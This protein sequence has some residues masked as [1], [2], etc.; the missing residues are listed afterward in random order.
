M[1]AVQEY[2]CE[3]VVIDTVSRSIE[4]EENSNDT[5]LNFYK[6]TGLRLKQAGVALIRLDHSGKD[7]MRGQRGASAKSG[8]VDAVWR[9]SRA[10][11]DTFDL[12]CEA[13]RFPIAQSEIVIRRVEEPVLHHKV[14]GSGFLVLSDDL[15]ESMEKAGV[16]RDLDMPI[17]ELR[18]YGA[19]DWILTPA[20]FTP[21]IAIL[22][23]MCVTQSLLLA[24]HTF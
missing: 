10:G 19:T 22:A 18:R 20:A 7:E 1:A 6:H 15:L 3:I 12:V 8:D 5:W 9:L 16:P 24:T 4:G 14:E 23:S 13:Q 17:H 2:G 21:T 11:E